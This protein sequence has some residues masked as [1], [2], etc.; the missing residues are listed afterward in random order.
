MG[1]DSKVCSQ[2][3]TAVGA[4][5]RVCTFSNVVLVLVG[6][7]MAAALGGRRPGGVGAVQGADEATQTLLNGVRGDVAQRLNRQE[8]TEFQLISYT[9]QV[10]AGTNYFAKMRIGTNELGDDEYVHIRV[11]SRPWENS[12]VLHGIQLDKTLEDTVEYF[13]MN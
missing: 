2:A 13:D 4:M 6:A 9:S 1:R 10:V 8:L 3:A 5:N 12:L 7:T 11:Y